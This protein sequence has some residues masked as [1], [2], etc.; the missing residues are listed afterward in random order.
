MFRRLSIRKLNSNRSDDNDEII[1]KRIEDHFKSFNPV[2]NY[3]RNN[4]FHFYY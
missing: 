1:R 4:V 3:F 2:E